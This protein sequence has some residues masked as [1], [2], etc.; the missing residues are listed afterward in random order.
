MNFSAEQTYS[1]IAIRRNTFRDFVEAKTPF[2]LIAIFLSKASHTTIS[3]N[4][5]E[6]I[7]GQAI[8]V[9]AGT[10][11]TENVIIRANHAKAIMNNFISVSAE[12]QYGARKIIITDNLCE[13]VGG[14]GVYLNAVDSFVVANNLLQVR[15]TEALRINPTGSNQESTNGVIANNVFI[16]P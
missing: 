14:F 3:E 7:R 5:F 1:N 6:N 13:L 2:G 8:S 10:G 15:A 11:N 4:H 16:N 12:G 9:K